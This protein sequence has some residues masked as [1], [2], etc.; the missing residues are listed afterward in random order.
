MFRF[1]KHASS[2]LFDRTRTTRGFVKEVIE[3]NLCILIGEERGTPRRHYLFYSHED[4]CCFVAVIDDQT[5]EIITVLPTDYHN[6]WRISPEAQVMAKDL[7]LNGNNSKFSKKPEVPSN[8]KKARLA[9]YLS[10][11]K[12]LKGPIHL[13]RFNVEELQE[14]LSI[15]NSKPEIVKKIMDQ[16]LGRLLRDGDK[17]EALVWNVNGEKKEANPE[18]ISRYF[19]D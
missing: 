6:R 12:G 5:K 13:G 1:T 14:L 16:N 7:V 8:Q 2:Q 18:I 9:C 3:K 17:L 15:P 10:S 11:G 19:Y 4:D